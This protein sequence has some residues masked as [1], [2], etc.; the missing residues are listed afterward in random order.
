[1][2]MI[3]ILIAFVLILGVFYDETAHN[4]IDTCEL[5]SYFEN[6]FEAPD[7]AVPL[8]IILFWINPSWFFS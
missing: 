8:W 7:G 1:M 4:A 2:K 3:A 6:I 5:S